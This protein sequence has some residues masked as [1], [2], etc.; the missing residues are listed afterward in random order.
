VKK[1][2]TPDELEW[3]LRKLRVDLAANFDSATSDESKLAAKLRSV[4]Q[5]NETL[6]K[7]E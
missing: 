4:L 7:L 6:L 5:Q 2:V 1:A 3:A